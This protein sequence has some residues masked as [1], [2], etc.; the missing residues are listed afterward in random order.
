[1]AVARFGPVSL[2]RRAET[3]NVLID[4][5]DPRPH[6]GER[7]GA[8]IA[9]RILLAVA[10]EDLALDRDVDPSGTKR[11]GVTAAEGEDARLLDAE[12]VSILFTERLPQVRLLLVR[13]R[14]LA[15][16][17]H[18]AGPEEV[19]ENEEDV[20]HP[21]IE[22]QGFDVV[23]IAPRDDR[24]E[25]ETRGRTSREA[26]HLARHDRVV[27]LVEVPL[28]T[29]SVRLACDHGFLIHAI[30]QR[31]HLDDHGRA[32]IVELL[33][34]SIIGQAERRFGEHNGSE[35]E[36]RRVSDDLPEVRIER[37]FA[38]ADEVH[39]PR[40]QRRRLADDAEA[41]NER[42]L[43]REPTL[44]RFWARV[45]LGVAVVA[46]PRTVVAHA[47][48]G[49]VEHSARI[50]GRRHLLAREVPPAHHEPVL[51]DVELRRKIFWFD[52]GHCPC[53]FSR[54]PARVDPTS[55]LF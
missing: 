1:M 35:A 29:L 5:A 31:V 11:A 46:I 18:P 27:A 53:L 42:E 2:A 52:D 24:V 4:V 23:Q 38:R 3:H 16:V 14:I 20:A 15:L 43:R 22:M 50:D 51:T 33:D 12:A 44:L 10:P 13:E 25:A 48:E 39:R 49:H 26:C 8:Q 19:L 17:L 41:I 6:V 7:L 55:T 21:R 28:R 47:L 36:A 34:K 45:A 37:G 9:E 40:A 30:P 54:H 32:Q